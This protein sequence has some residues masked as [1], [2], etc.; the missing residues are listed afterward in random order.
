MTGFLLAG[1]GNVDLRRKTNFLVVNE[2]A[3]LK[4]PH[5]PLRA[6]CQTPCHGC[7]WSSASLAFAGSPRRGAASIAEHT[8]A[9]TPDFAAQLEA[10]GHCGMLVQRRR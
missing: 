6:S 2:S 5:L 7:Y 3:L 8:V 10:E 9:Q 4:P 1:V